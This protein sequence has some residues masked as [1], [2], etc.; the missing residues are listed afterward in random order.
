M[1][2]IPV[3]D[4]VLITNEHH[5]TAFLITYYYFFFSILIL[6]NELP[7][8]GDLLAHCFHVES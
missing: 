1:D 8:V 7:S 3:A 6:K 5:H 2:R 4:L